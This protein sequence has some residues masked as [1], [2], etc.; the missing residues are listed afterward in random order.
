MK[1]IVV[2]AVFC[3]AAA[4]MSAIFS[5]HGNGANAGTVEPAGRN[6]AI[7]KVDPTAATITFRDWSTD[8]IRSDAMG[9]YN[10]Q[11]QQNYLDDEL[12]L[13]DYGGTHLGKRS[14]RRLLFGALPAVATDC[15][16]NANGPDIDAFGD[17]PTIAVKHVGD[18]AQYNVA[19]AR[20][21]MVYTSAGQFNFGYR[22]LGN[23]PGMHCSMEVVVTRHDQHTW[24]ITT[25]AAPDETLIDDTLDPL[26][27]VSNPVPV[28]NQAQLQNSAA[29]FVGNYHLSFGITVYC[30]LCK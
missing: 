9:S 3:I 21:A 4:M 23:D 19:V 11:V 24:F 15:D 5:A 12:L 28:G 8:Q 2:L 30:P 14:T 29:Y 10:G 17:T 25:D 6:A 18:I 7:A 20:R 1:R 27:G 13:K 22:N 16:L 26:W